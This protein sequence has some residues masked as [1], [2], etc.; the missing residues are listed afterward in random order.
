MFWINAAVLRRVGANAPKTWDEFFVVA[1]KLKQMGTPMLAVGE[2]A[3]QIATMFEAI[4]CGLG[5]AAFYNAAFSK[6]DQ[7]ALNGPVMIRCLE[8]LRQMKPYCTPD[9]AGRE[10]NLATADVINGRAAMQLMGDWAKGEFAQAGKV[11]GVD[12]LCVP[13][14]TQ[15]GEYSFAADTLTMFK[16]SEPRLQAAQRD[17]VSLLMSTEGQEV[18]NLYKGNIP[19]RTDVN[20]SRY[21]D[22]AKQSARDFANAANKQV[23]VPSWAHN[24]AVQDEV[25]LAFYDAVDAFWKNSSMSAQDAARRFAD[26]ARR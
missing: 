18:F 5:G 9:A 10:W 11:Q 17:F 8:T 2:Q 3:W 21:D 24:M 20:L 4:T 19:A 22:Y 6:L 23:L 26:A 15:N 13:A 14:P 7:A 12:Y 1:E 16:Q 25:K